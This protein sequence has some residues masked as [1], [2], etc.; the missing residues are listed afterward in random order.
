MTS[1]C[2]DAKKLKFSYIAGGNVNGAA[3]VE[4]RWFFS[5]LNI[6]LPNDPTIS[7]LGIYTKYLKIGVQ[8]VTC[9]QMFIV[10]LFTIGKMWK[11]LKCHKWMNG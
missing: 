6:E 1:V 2:E 11:Q 7:L 5:K 9:M 8:I 4:N 3:T 10:A